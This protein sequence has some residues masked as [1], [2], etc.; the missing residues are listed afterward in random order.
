MGKHNVWFIADLHLA[1]KN[2]LKH[3]PNRI[4]WLGLKDEN[5]IETHDKKILEIWNNTVKPG[6]C[7]YL[8]GD[9]ILSN[10]EKVLELLSQ[11]KS[12]GCALI[13]IVGN[14]DKEITKFT[15]F[16]KT[17]EICKYVEFK[18][19]DFPFIEEDR[20]SCV[21]C[22]Y[23][24]KSW[25]NKCRGSMQIYGHVHDNSP[26]IDEEDDLTMNVGFD[27]CHAHGGLVSLEQVYSFYK[28]KLNG[29]SPVNYVN[30]VSESN[31]KFIK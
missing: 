4:E 21:L 17:I 25:M 10:R 29:L 22:H 12:K 3:Q 9:I 28:T 18:K 8:L 15:R 7:V 23:P 1:H 16:F 14:H 19:K 26:W 13:L 6:D 27:A 20:F 11:L 2:I 30:K 31:K 5:D 24:L